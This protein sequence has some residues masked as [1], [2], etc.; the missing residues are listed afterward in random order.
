MDFTRRKV[1]QYVPYADNRAEFSSHGTHVAGTIIGRR[2]VDGRTETE[3][4]ADGVA[5]E[6]KIAFFDI[7]DGES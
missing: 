1:V 5:P 2:A 3:G 7:G 6:A 4:I